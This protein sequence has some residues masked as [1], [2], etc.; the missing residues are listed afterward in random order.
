MQLPDCCFGRRW[1]VS[2][3]SRTALAIDY[4]GIS[5]A[6]LPEQMVIW[7]LNLHVQSLSAVYV[8][9]SLALGDVLPTTLAEFDANEVLFRDLGQLIA[10]RPA[11][12]VAFIPYS[13]GIN[14]RMPVASKG[15]RL[16]GR[17][18]GSALVAT[19]SMATIVVSSIPTEVPDCLV[20]E[21]LRSQ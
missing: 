11:V 5:N 6:G 19:F 3:A 14:M 17:F 1:P 18:L 7:E 10:L 8:E 20:S 2:V 15:R 9:M 12:R 4:F 21:Y 13:F 16:I